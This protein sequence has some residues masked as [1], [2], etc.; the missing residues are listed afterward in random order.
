MNE[1]YSRLIQKRQQVA[2]N[3]GFGNYRD[4]KFVEMGR[5]DYGKKDCYLFHE[6]VRQHV[7]PLV[8]QIYGHKKKKLGLDSLRP[9]DIDAE[10]AGI[11]PLHPFKNR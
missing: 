6:A 10:P 8:D 7:M 3:T 1:L 11:E 5:F 4:Y 2:L 9:W